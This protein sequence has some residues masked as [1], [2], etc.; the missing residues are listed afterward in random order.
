MVLTIVLKRVCMYKTYKTYMY[1]EY[2]H[3]AAI[4][5][6][7]NFYECFQTTQNNAANYESDKSP[8]YYNYLINYTSSS[9]LFIRPRRVYT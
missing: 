8:P 1:N 6:F 7:L 9:S 5:E 4:C 2:A 3:A